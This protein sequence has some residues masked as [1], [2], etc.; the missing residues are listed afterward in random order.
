[1]HTC[2]AYTKKDK[3]PFEKIVLLYTPSVYAARMQTH[4]HLW[5]T[6]V[7]S[8]SGGARGCGA[9]ILTSKRTTMQN[10]ASA[11]PT[12]V[13]DKR[14]R[15]CRTENRRCMSKYRCI[16]QNGPSGA[17]KREKAYKAAAHQLAG[18]EKNVYSL[19]WAACARAQRTRGCPV[20]DS[21]R[22]SEVRSRPTS[23]IPPIELLSASKGLL[24]GHMPALHRSQLPSPD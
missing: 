17:F 6:D 21:R 15:K 5:P 16:I 4:I 14:A 1:M 10:R 8:R 20:F 18:R 12:S 13:D 9:K 19:R 24:M 7:R 3:L 2:R 23:P 11:P 22:Y